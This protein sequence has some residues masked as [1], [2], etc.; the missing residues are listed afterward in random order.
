MQGDAAC[1]LRVDWRFLHYKRHIIPVMTSIVPAFQY[2]L[3]DH[4]AHECVEFKWQ[5]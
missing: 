5:Q 4:G 1:L 2:L 3:V